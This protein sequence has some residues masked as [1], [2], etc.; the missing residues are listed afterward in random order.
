MEK[1]GIIEQV[2]EEV[3][4]SGKAAEKPLGKYCDHTVL[5]AYTTRETVKQFCEEAVRCGA[6]SVCVNPVHV[7]YVHELLRGTGLYTC[8][9]IGF[10]LGYNTTAVKV[11]EAE[12]AIA[13]GSPYVVKADTLEDL[14]AKMGIKD[15]DAFLKTIE[16]YNSVK[17][18]DDP[19][20]AFGVP[21]NQLSFVEEGPFY[22][23]LMVSLNA[24]TMGG[25]QTQM[26]GEV[27]DVYGEVMPGLYAC[28]EASNGAIYDRGY[29]SGTSVLNCYVAG[30]DAGNSAAAFAQE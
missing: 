9:V 13:E 19:D 5:R 17:G 29:I 4:P 16:T 26:T 2:R 14:A 3:F 12:Q 11:F 10:P 21:N 8:T 24:G 6:A 1:N 23:V 27:L 15:V 25:I 18:T 7:A 28:G 22:G 20:P 30:R